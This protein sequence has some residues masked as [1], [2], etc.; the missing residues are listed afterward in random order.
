MSRGKSDFLTKKHCAVSSP[1]LKAGV[2][3]AHFKIMSVDFLVCDDIR[4]ENNGKLILT[5]VYSD[6]IIVPE[7]PC[8]VPSLSFFIR[9]SES[10]RVLKVGLH[11]PSGQLLKETVVGSAENESVA[12]IVYIKNLP[13]QMEGEYQVVMQDD[14]HPEL[15]EY[16][17][18]EVKLEK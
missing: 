15:R 11:E 5:G 17:S 4:I 7:L 14:S 16:R 12:F 6:S 1:R 18:F 13:L 3:T 8:T 9:C 10:P 2:S